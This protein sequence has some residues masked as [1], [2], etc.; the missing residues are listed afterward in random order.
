MFFIHHGMIYLLAS[1][2]S[3]A[4]IYV[5]FRVAKNYNCKLNLLITLNYLVASVL[6]FAVLLKFEFSH[7]L[8]N[9][10]WLPYG[11][12]LG[13]LF[14]LMF[15]LIGNS[16]QKAGIA[17][18]TLANKLSLVFPVFFSLLFFDESITLLKYAGLIS[19]LVAISLTVYKKDVRK[20]KWTY[21]VLPL[22]LFVGSGI[23]DSLIKYV[24]AT[25]ITHEQTTAYTTFVF[26]TA[27][28]CGLFFSLLKTT[29][30]SKP[31]HGP[32]WLLGLLLGLVNFGSLWFFINALNKSNLE[33]S[34]VFALNNM[35]IVAL[36]AILGAFLFREKLNKFN[37]AGIVLALISLYILLR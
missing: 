36:S 25:Q 3:S 11:I 7:F 34:L 31:F 14:I 8:D 9:N 37:L 19:A 6:G 21:I 22:V 23:T 17:V 35:S 10:N 16:S 5:I 24:Q 4:S 18:T 32:S 26:F 27:F 30:Q 13:V 2:I 15:F 29:A 33:S 1:I 20:T 28:V 12:A